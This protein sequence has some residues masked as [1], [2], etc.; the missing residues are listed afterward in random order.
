MI[1]CKSS[2]PALP[3]LFFSSISV[4]PERYL[5]FVRSNYWK[6][7]IMVSFSPVAIDSWY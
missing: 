1:T 5:S 4:T 7:A 3:H 6:I 2:S